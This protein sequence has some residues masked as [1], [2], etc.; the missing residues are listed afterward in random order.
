MALINRVSRLFQ[1]DFNAVLD[2]IEEPELLLRHAVREMEDELDHDEQ[3]SRLLN[4]EV[5]QLVLRRRNIEQALDSIEEELDIC[6]EADNDELARP[7]VTRKL[8]LLQA[9]RFLDEKSESLCQSLD[10]LN[11]RISENRSRLESM[12]QKADLL[13]ESDQHSSS[14]TLIDATRFSIDKADVEVALLREKQKRSRS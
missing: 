5:K 2:R 4:H 8:E 14:E 3:R 6:F 1:A 13:A 12:R 11:T 7:L 9:I 10:N